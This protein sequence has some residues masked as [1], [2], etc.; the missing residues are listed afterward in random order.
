MTSTAAEV[1]KTRVRARSWFKSDRVERSRV[2]SIS[3]CRAETA[4]NSGNPSL[5]ALIVEAAPQAST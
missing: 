1:K 3:L 4:S 5:F 2:P